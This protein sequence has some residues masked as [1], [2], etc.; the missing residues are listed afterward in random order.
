MPM[1]L[2]DFNPSAWKGMI[3]IGGQVQAAVAFESKTGDSASSIRVRALPLTCGRGAG[4]VLRQDR[5]YWRL[6][7]Y[8][9]AKRDHDGL[10]ILFPQS[11]PA[12]RAGVPAVCHAMSQKCDWRKV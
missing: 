9:A 5:A 11:L 2:T 10:R 8:E 1:A 12:V 7:V 3:G 4:P 6:P